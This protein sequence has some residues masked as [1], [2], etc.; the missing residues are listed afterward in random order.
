MKALNSKE[1]EIILSL[2]EAETKS[3]KSKIDAFLFMNECRGGSKIFSFDNNVHWEGSETFYCMR[4]V[5]NDGVFRLQGVKTEKD[6]ETILI[7]FPIDDNGNLVS[8]ISHLVNGMKMVLIWERL[9]DERMGT[10]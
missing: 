2:L 5:E 4:V 6:Q 10:K 1:R 3:M 9:L 8:L 7:D